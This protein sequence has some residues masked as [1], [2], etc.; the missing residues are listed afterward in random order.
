MF[1][2]KCL[3]MLAIALTPCKLEHLYA[4]RIAMGFVGDDLTGNWLSVY[5]S[6]TVVMHIAAT[7][8]SE[9][10]KVANTAKISGYK[11]FTCVVNGPHREHVK[12]EFILRFESDEV[13][14]FRLTK[15]D[16]VKQNTGTGYELTNLHIVV[17]SAIP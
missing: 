6:A 8:C 12:V 11:N 14:T 2:S 5:D 1:M 17:L 16:L 15:H 10:E 4:I 7:T 13:D 3:P 9:Y